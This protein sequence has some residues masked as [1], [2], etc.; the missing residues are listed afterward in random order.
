MAKEERNL[1]LERTV[2]PREPWKGLG[3]T[4]E[5]WGGPTE[6]PKGAFLLA[7]LDTRLKVCEELKAQSEEICPHLRGLNQMRHCWLLRTMQGGKTSMHVRGPD[8]V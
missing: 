8:L 3:C 1:S 6:E 2:G 5:D 7:K 4:P